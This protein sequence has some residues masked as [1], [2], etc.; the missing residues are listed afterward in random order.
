MI[1]IINK[2]LKLKI[3]IIFHSMKKILFIVF[4][5]SYFFSENIFAENILDP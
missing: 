5:F 4:I 1:F 3:L 2:K